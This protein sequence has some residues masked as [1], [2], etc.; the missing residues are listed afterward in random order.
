MWWVLY[1][2]GVLTTGQWVH[3]SGLGAFVLTALFQG[4]TTMTENISKS[5]YPAYV[6]YQRRTSRLLPW[7]PRAG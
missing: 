7:F 2:Y 1:G 4:S 3:W 5:K 6:E